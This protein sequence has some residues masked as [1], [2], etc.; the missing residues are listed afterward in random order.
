[1]TGVFRRSSAFGAASFPM[2]WEAAE[3]GVC[4]GSWVPE[5]GKPEVIFLLVNCNKPK[6]T[7]KIV[8][9]TIAINHKSALLSFMLFKDFLGRL[10]WR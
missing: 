2:A 4:D 9:T 3:L 6:M 1:V 7:R 5:Y 10:E 8:K